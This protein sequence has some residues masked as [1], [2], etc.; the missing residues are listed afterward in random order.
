[1]IDR[2][3]KLSHYP[4]YDKLKCSELKS[5]SNL[6]ELVAICGKNENPQ[7]IVTSSTSVG[8]WPWM[9]SLGFRNENGWTHQCGSS[10]ISS[11]LVTTAAH[12][13]REIAKKTVK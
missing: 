13:A 1:M 6:D 4:S 2:V 3:P 9:G 8:N 10:L 7:R 12:C 5:L 11:T